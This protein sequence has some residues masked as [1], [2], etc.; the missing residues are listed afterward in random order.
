MCWLASITLSMCVPALLITQVG[1]KVVH[2][3]GVMD[4]FPRYK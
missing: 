1:E 4:H 2:F 3:W